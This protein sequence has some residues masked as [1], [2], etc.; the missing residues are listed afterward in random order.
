MVGPRAEREA[1]N[2]SV[3]REVGDVHLTKAVD[4]GG[5]VVGDVAGAIDADSVV[6]VA[7]YSI[8]STDFHPENKKGNYDNV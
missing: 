5:E 7:R 4:D 1:T 3:K 8:A 2:L 6:F